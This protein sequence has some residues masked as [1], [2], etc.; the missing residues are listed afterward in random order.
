MA[1]EELIQFTG[2]VIELL[3]NAEFRIR[4]DETDDRL[5]DVISKDKKDSFVITAYT[6]GKMRQNRIRIILNDKVSIAM[7][8]YDLTRGRVTHRH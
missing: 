4:L 3:P 7:S 5:K 6:G 1:K 8:T 2:T